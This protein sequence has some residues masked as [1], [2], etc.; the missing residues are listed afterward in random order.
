MEK[1]NYDYKWFTLRVFGLEKD[2][3][4]SAVGTLKSIGAIKD[5]KDA[6]VNTPHKAVDISIRQDQLFFVK[7]L[8]EHL[9]GA[10]IGKTMV[11]E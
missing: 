2:V 10:N 3:L 7:E 6:D 5:I 11:V 4:E 8:I 1:K 9:D